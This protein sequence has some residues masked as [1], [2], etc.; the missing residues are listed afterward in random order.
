MKCECV[1][2]CT[3]LKYGGGEQGVCE[4]LCAGDKN[5][6]IAGVRRKVSK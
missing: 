1:G 2:K 6:V 4:K 5:R 3:V